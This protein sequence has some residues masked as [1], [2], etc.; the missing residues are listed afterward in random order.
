MDQIIVMDQGSVVASGTHEE[1]ISTSVLYRKL[2]QAHREAGN[3]L[4][5]VKEG[6]QDV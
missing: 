4:F 3:W 6:P 5:P 2:W 1:L